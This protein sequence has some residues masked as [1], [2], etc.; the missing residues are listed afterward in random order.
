MGYM[1]DKIYKDM[2]KHTIIQSEWE[3]VWGDD[4]FNI[5]TGHFEKLNHDLYY[6]HWES[7]LLDLVTN[8]NYRWLPSIKSLLSLVRDLV[9]NMA[10]FKE[11]Y[12]IELHHKYTVTIQDDSLE[13]CLLRVFMLEAHD[14]YWEDGWMDTMVPVYS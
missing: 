9:L 14:L 3:P 8:S 4:I 1:E 12:R 11:F 5:F 2:C 13:K 7:D 6:A 10:Q